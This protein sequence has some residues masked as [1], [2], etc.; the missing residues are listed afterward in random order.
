MTSGL[1]DRRLCAQA[2]SCSSCGSP[3][4]VVSRL[5]AVQAQDRP[6]SKWAIGL[7][8]RSSSEGDIEEAV[9]AQRIIRTWLMRGTL[10]FV[11]AE[12][13]R[14]ILQ[15]IAPRVMAAS[16]R[17]EGQLHLDAGVFERSAALLG[18]AMGD[19]PIAR[20][21]AMELLEGRGISTVGGRGYH[22]LWHLAL[23]GLL[24]FGPM[25]GGEPTFVLLDRW[26]PSSASRTPH[27]PWVELARRYFHGHGPATARD[28]ASWSGLPIS[29]VRDAIDTLGSSLVEESVGG[30]RYWSV[31]DGPPLLDDGRFYLLPAFDE[32]I[33]GY[34]DRTAVLDDHHTKA[35]LS[36][37]GIFFPTMV[38]EG[39]VRG[40]WRAIK[41]KDEVI[42]ETRPFSPLGRAEVGSLKEA[43]DRYGH[44]VQKSVQVIMR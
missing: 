30:E 42:V 13:L 7:R 26:A 9:T 8:A 20:S 19:G 23:I 28:L 44:F 16:R 35:V 43:A 40:T 22:I 27:R 6:S 12:D 24:C 31:P 15:L 14:W 18:E 10:H 41:R 1:P 37:N 38:F 3:Q 11:A 39:T 17:R 25:A 2:I 36:S 29:M 33:I 34:R 32:Y 5:C 4:E 21:A